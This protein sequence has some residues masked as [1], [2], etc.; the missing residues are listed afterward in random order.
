MVLL[1][2]ISQVFHLPDDDGGAMRCVV[3]LDSG[4]IGL[5]AIDGK[6]GGDPVSMD[7]LREK[8]ERGFCIPLLREQEVNGLPGLIDRAIHIPPLAF[9][10]DIG[11]I[12]P[13]AAAHWALAAVERL[14]QLRTVLHDP[15]LDRRV[16]DW[17][18][19]L[20]H[21]FFDMPITPGVRHIPPYTHQ[22]NLLWEMGPLE[23]HWHRLFPPLAT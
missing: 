20:L 17:H 12:H 18:P 14:C 21:Q 22:N 1:D 16:V 2:H 10:P 6:R 4:F 15:A 23:A 5:A 8:S 9:H 13:P 19:A 3:P 7:G 11:L